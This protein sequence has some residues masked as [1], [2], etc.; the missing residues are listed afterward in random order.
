MTPEV[1]NT[2]VTAMDHIIN[3]I[4]N[5]K[6]SS[7]G[8]HDLHVF[9]RKL[10]NIAD[11]KKSGHLTGKQV[12]DLFTRLS[13]A[14][15]LVSDALSAR[16]SR[17]NRFTLDQFV[18]MFHQIYH[19]SDLKQLFIDHTSNGER[20]T[21]SQLVTFMIETQK[22]SAFTLDKAHELIKLLE[23]DSSSNN[24]NK[25][26]HDVVDTTVEVG[27]N[28]KT[29]E[30]YEM[31]D[32]GTNEQ[33]TL[34]QDGFIKLMTSNSLNSAR[35]DCESVTHDMN[36]PLS[37]YFIA[38]SHNTY[39]MSDQL[40]GVSSGDAYI[41]ALKAGCRS[42]ELDVWDGPDDEPIIYHGHTL[43]SQILLRDVCEIIADYAF[44]TSQYPLILSIENHCSPPFE[45]KMAEYFYFI[46]GDKLL[47]EPIAPNE[48]K[49]PSPVQLSGKIIIKGKRHRKDE[50]ETDESEE[51]AVDEAGKPSSGQPVTSS[52]KQSIKTPVKGA[53][54]KSK[55]GEV[56]KVKD[57]SGARAGNVTSLQSPSTHAAVKSLP[58]T[59]STVLKSSDSVTQ[60][61]SSPPLL[62]ELKLRQREAR[63]AFFADLD[64]KLPNEVP[65]DPFTQTDALQLPKGKIDDDRSRD[66][67]DGG[68][69]VSTLRP[70]DAHERT[71]PILLTDLIVYC[72]SRR[73]TSF[74]DSLL[75][76]FYE[77]SSFSEVKAA[78]L[79]AREANGFISYNRNHLSRIYPRG[80]RTDSSNM[81]PSQFW[82]VGC[83]L[84]ALN[85][86]TNDT[87]NRTN[88][89][90]FKSNGSSGF[91]LKPLHLRGQRMMGGGSDFH[92]ELLGRC[93]SVPGSPVHSTGLP[94][95]KSSS[96]S[97][98]NCYRLTI[99]VISGQFLSRPSPSPT[100][101]I[102]DPYVQVK[103]YGV[104]NEKKKYSTPHVHNN[105][106]NPV[107]PANESTF[108]F[109]IID[110]EL[111]FVELKVKDHA[112]I[113][114]NVKVGYC[115][116]PVNQLKF[117]Y[118]TVQLEDVTGK[119]LW[120]SGLFVLIKKTSAQ[121]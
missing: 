51:D 85:Y 36:Q 33:L 74:D 117:G 6:E 12:K 119:S 32:A 89:S 21:A 121:S 45:Q 110:P 9:L 95:F 2:W 93:S 10:F 68:G 82:S 27:G 54:H 37:H 91:I 57:T 31:S 7:A 13:V 8:Y 67:D 61:P 40:I 66:D 56:V 15:E 48:D 69:E 113:Q 18:Q 86:Q 108:T 16:L 60:T 100:D 107:W 84:V 72:V 63:N 96:S 99:Q 3:H 94:P 105:G 101:D 78:K 120:P 116:I 73:F 30:K 98:N 64:D 52:D 83:Q 42:V 47:Q 114:S 28:D 24:N 34:S 104:P 5:P 55:K 23:D 1:R 103:V 76:K 35:I 20:M 22:E 90:L 49:W 88:R 102:I 14:S 106:L 97:S 81:E 71:T 80:T 11:V 43:V 77:M 112:N 39:L 87:A 75:W 17:S 70:V 38:T 29:G 109:D 115:I 25:P 59:P 62:E 118:R 58:S 19:R 46:L 50:S 92:R 44:T 4:I 111:A 41:R 79:I 53:T 26:P 65:V